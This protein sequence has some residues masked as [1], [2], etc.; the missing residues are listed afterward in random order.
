MLKER[1]PPS[2]PFAQTHYLQLALPVRLMVRW[3][4]MTGGWRSTQAKK[5]K[6][7]ACCCLLCLLLL[8]LRASRASLPSSLPAV[9]LLCL[10]FRLA[11]PRFV[12]AASLRLLGRLVWLRCGCAGACAGARSLFSPFFSPCLLCGRLALS[13]HSSCLVHALVPRW[14]LLR[15]NRAPRW[16]SHLAPFFVHGRR[17]HLHCKPWHAP[18]APGDVMADRKC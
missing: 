7:L 17:K 14:L 1:F 9:R 4:V 15:L 6:E 2:L 18:K 11:L 12:L 8:P 3:R 10:R 13:L 16:I 5:G